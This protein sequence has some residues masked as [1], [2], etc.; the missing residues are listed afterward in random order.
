MLTYNTRLHGS[1]S[2]AEDAGEKIVR[3]CYVVKVLG[4]WLSDLLCTLPETLPARQ[5]TAGHGPPAWRVAL[6]GREHTSS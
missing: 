6:V 4:I 5:L 2:A 3:G 1:G